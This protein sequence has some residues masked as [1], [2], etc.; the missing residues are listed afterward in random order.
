MYV[1]LGAIILLLLGTTVYYTRQ[2]RVVPIEE[3]LDIPPD[4]RPVYD[5]VSS[6]MEQ[7]G[8]QAILALGLQGGYVEVPPALKKQPLGRISLDPYN[9]FVVPYW[10]YKEERRIPSLAEMENQIS[11]RVTAGMPDCVRFDETGL[12]VKENSDFAMVASTDDNVILTAKWELTI[13]EGDKSTPLDKYIVRIPVALKE[14]YDAAIKIYQAEGDG[15]FLANLTLDLMTINENIPMAGMEISCQKKRWRTDEVSAE[16][17]DM[18]KGLL[19]LVRVKNTDHKPFEASNR[20]YTKLAKDA[21]LLQEMLLDERVQDLSSDFDNPRQSGDVK[22]L[23]KRLKKAPEDSYEFF[24][25]YLDANLPKND[26]RVTVEHQPEWGILF[27]VQPRDGQKMVSN[28]AKVGAMLKF[29]CFNQ[30]HFN[31]D[32]SYPVMF[33]INDPDS[34]TGDGFTFQF[35]MPVSIDDNQA[36]RRDASLHFFEGITPGADFCEKIGTK[37]ADIRA[38]GALEGQDFFAELEGT[39]ITYTCLNKECE[40]GTTRADE[41]GYRLFTLL[42]R[43][44]T[45]PFITAQHSGYLT[46]TLQLKEDKLTIP[47]KRLKKLPVNIVKHTYGIDESIGEG[48][49]LESFEKATIALY[50]LGEDSDQFGESID[51]EA[52]AK[53]IVRLEGRPTPPQDE[54]ARLR[55]TIRGIPMSFAEQ[56]QQYE[57]SIYL[58]DDFG[59]VIGGYHNDNLT[60]SGQAIRN[61]QGVD[62]HVF[63]FVPTPSSDEE[64]IIMT[65]LM[66]EGESN[67]E[68]APTFT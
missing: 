51:K 60:I 31:Y 34:F 39:N 30:F 55:E 29:L 61:A 23:G 40:I 47:L 7:L 1:L 42:P 56:D 49:N 10:Y 11:N 14:V 3:Q 58:R 54:I 64:K 20:V 59:N 8:R 52:V 66:F 35:A 15:L 27:N 45:N 32:V 22:A 68:V 16:I 44:C 6:C 19:P 65:T 48:Q 67:E 41:G 24:N 38:Q 33:R 50:M 18:M 25:M 13:I 26:F 36:I 9:E 37:T 4:A 43:G 21:A 12:Q 57:L 2:V 28:R 17:Q 62:L 63:R 46:N 5:I 53:T